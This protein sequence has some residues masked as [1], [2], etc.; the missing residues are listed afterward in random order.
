MELE[1]FI[2]PGKLRSEIGQGN[3]LS[4]IHVSERIFYTGILCSYLSD[5]LPVCF[6]IVI[7]R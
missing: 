6:S 7:H 5:N 2:L 4:L 3:S 1:S